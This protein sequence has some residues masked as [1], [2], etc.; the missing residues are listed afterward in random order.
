MF[1][2]AFMFYNDIMY[3]K[4]FNKIHEPYAIDDD[5]DINELIVQYN[6]SLIDFQYNIKPKIPY[7]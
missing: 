7:K 4:T 5:V 2:F 3:H 1:I 6:K